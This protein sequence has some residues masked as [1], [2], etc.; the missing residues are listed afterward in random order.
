MSQHQFP[1]NKYILRTL[2]AG[3]PVRLVTLTD[4]VQFIMSVPGRTSKLIRT[5][6]ANVVHRFIAGEANLI[7]NMPLVVYANDLSARGF[8]AAQEVDLEGRLVKRKASL[9]L[10][11]ECPIVKTCLI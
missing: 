2:G 4:S 8:R 3:S 6:F 9:S 1:S 5:R 10:F 11:G 7:K